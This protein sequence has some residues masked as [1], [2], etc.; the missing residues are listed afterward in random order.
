VK[1]MIRLGLVLSLALVGACG[2]GTPS[3]DAGPSDSGTPSSDAST[4]DRA[5]ACAAYCTAVTSACTGANM[6]YASM[7]ACVMAC[8]S[9]SYEVGTTG[10]TMG[11]SIACRTYHAGVAAM[12]A[13][14]AMVHCPHASASGGGVCQ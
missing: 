8:S 13:M 6:Q 3:G 14:N 1:T 5:T 12:S 7:D 10:A 4:P 9:A 2:G 11:N